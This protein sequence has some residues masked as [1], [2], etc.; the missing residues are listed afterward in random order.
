MEKTRNEIVVR[1]RI[2]KETTTK[3]GTT[4]ITVVTKSGSLDVFLRFVCKNVEVPAHTK[5]AHVVV[6]GHAIG[7]LHRN[8]E[9]K[10]EY[11]QYLV[12]DDVQLENTML[13]DAFGVQGK[14]FPTPSVSYY[15][16]GKLVAIF[17]DGDWY[18]YVVEMDSQDGSNRRSRVRMNMKKLDRHPELEKGDI[19]CA[20]A[21]ISSPKKV[22]DGK[23]RY[24]EDVIISDLAKVDDVA[25]TL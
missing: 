10:T 25:D 22:I 6:T 13:Q 12:A 17:E 18:R 23:T 5:R 7:Y 14:F 9:G 15:I 20:I 19:V 1:G 21:T 16:T 2:I 3:N 4:I 8:S 24:F 11:E